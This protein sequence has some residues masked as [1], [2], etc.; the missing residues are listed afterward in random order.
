MAFYDKYGTIKL[1]Y[2]IL[3]IYAQK[4]CFGTACGPLGFFSAKIKIFMV[5]VCLVSFHKIDIWRF[6]NCKFL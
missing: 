4:R 2:I 3:K 5:V 6:M 1:K